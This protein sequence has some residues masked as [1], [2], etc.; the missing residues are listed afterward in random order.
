MTNTNRLYDTTPCLDPTKGCAKKKL[1][2]NNTYMLAYL[3]T[4]ILAYL[5]SCIL[6][7]LHTRFPAYFNTCNHYETCITHY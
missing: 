6:A 3:H 2:F 4:C 1:P 5:H 7:Y